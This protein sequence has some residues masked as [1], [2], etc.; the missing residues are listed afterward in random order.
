MLAGWRYRRAVHAYAA[1][2]TVTVGVWLI[3]FW[4]APA[5]LFGLGQ[6]FGN[7]MLSLGMALLGVGLE[8]GGAPGVLARAVV[9]SERLA[10]R[11]GVGGRGAGVPGRR[12]SIADPVGA[13]VRRPVP[14][15]RDPCP[16]PPPGEG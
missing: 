3:G 1:L 12:S 4:L 7:G 16:A 14:R 6:P 10:V 11:A 2:A 8:R 5:T 13:V 15:W 9:P